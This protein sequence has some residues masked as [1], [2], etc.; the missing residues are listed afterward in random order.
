MSPIA[1]ARAILAGEPIKVFNHGRMR[2]DFTFVDDIVEGVVR[3]LAILPAPCAESGART[4]SITSATTRRSGW[5][6]TST[7]WQ[8]RWAAKQSKDYQPMQAGDVPATYADT[9]RLAALTGFA[10]STPLAE[11]IARFVAWYKD[12]Y[13]C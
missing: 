11:G 5:R 8:P 3:T 7:P 9:T 6:I 10:P 1:F 13:R 12:Y 4:R 2:R